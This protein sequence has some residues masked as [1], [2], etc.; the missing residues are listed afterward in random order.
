MTRKQVIA[1]IDQLSK[2]LNHGCGNHGCVI[3]KS[4]GMKT[5]GPCRCTPIRV[6]KELEYLAR[7]IKENSGTSWK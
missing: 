6:A 7:E 3:N 2:T 4:A 1:L 5:N